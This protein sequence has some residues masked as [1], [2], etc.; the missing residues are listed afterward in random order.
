MPKPPNLDK[1]NFFEVWD[2]VRNDP[3]SN[4]LAKSIPDTICWN[5]SKHDGYAKFVSSKEVKFTAN[6]G[7]ITLTY[8]DFISRVRELYACTLALTKISLMIT[9]K[10]KTF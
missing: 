2:A 9:L 4:I 3:A 5:A 6:E 7:T 8:S 1:K 10:L